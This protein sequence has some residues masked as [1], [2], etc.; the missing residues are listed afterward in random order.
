MKVKQK[1]QKPHI[2]KI[3]V[4]TA[5]VLALLIVETVI[6][7]AICD[8]AKKVAYEGQMTNYMHSASRVAQ[9][10]DSAVE[11]AKDRTPDI[12]GTLSGKEFTLDDTSRKYSADAN[13]AAN[14]KS[15]GVNFYRLSEICPNT[16]ADSRILDDSKVYV[17]YSA[18]QSDGT[19]KLSFIDLSS[20]FKGS[21]PEGFDGITL[22][23]GSGRSEFV[24]ETQDDGS[25]L[26]LKGT[27]ENKQAFEELQK[28][29]L[30]LTEENLNSATTVKAGNAVFALS[31][32]Q[33]QTA[34]NY[35]VGG[36]DNFSE[37]QRAIDG[38]GTMVIISMIV[39]CVFTAVII[40]LGGYAFT[41][42]K[43]DIYSFTVDPEGNI[44]QSNKRFQEDF[45]DVHVITERLNRF[46]EDRTYSVHLE[47]GEKNKLISC[48]V[49]KQFDGTVDVV[50]CEL[51]VPVGNDIEIE[52]KDNLAA[53]YR[54]FSLEYSKVL[55]GEIYL[56]NI[57]EIKDV[58]GRDFAETIRNM[59]ID[60]VRKQFENIFVF[61][62]YTL[63]VLQ[64]EGKRLE[65]MMRDMERVVADINRVVKAGD[66]NVLINV[67]C[68]FAL[69]DS[70]VKSL[71]YDEVMSA[72]DAALK[73]ACEPQPDLINRV[74]FYVF[75]E[76]QRKFY[77]KYLFKIDI[78]QML[79]DG[80]FYLEYQPQYGLSEDRIIGFEALFRVQRKVQVN[81]S[82]MDIINYAE[83]S[84]NMVLL[85]NFI[86]NEG[87]KFA[88]SIEGRGVGVSL[89]VSPVQMMQT[90]FVDAFLK[91]YNSYELKPGSI[92]I[93]VTESYLVSDMGSTLKKLEVLRANGIDIHIDDFGTGYSSFAYLAKLPI[94]TIKIDQSFIRDMN[95]N[96]VNSIIT[97][98]LI[99][100]CK[101]LNLRSVCEGVENDEQLKMLREQGCDVIQGFVISR[102]VKEDIAR[103]MIDNYHYEPPVADGTAEKSPENK[104]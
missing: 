17:I 77:S 89:N 23:S 47:Q 5:M 48:S 65:I 88:K 40:Y 35:T 71:S 20:M 29:R 31:V 75:Q 76:S 9:A 56:S 34:S 15:R 70:T 61:D 51:T 82:V 62:Y 86:L 55:V 2:M 11:K 83:R 94:S 95:T 81:A 26:Q 3:I 18:P 84:G 67:K 74:D 41:N 53:M 42:R 54:A 80:D 96:K 68:G 37:G 78:P 7:I 13:I 98:T 60:R 64:P 12:T 69:S 91:L 22:F 79:A 52:R 90:G 43:K 16:T 44:I 102:S 85:G 39:I 10:L 27:G 57:S 50:G 99:D 49:K 8:R 19:V 14:L 104:K 101:N 6:G 100:V 46:D 73:R 97:G 32:A 45:P 30:S 63:A 59:L 24:A 36:Y 25:I 103:D 4:L 92:S 66:N 93:E 87:M 21:S 1:I 33:M 38:L 58:F 28:Y 72:A